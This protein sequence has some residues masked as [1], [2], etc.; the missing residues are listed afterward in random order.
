M[1]KFGGRNCLAER[2]GAEKDANRQWE[3]RGEGCISEPLHLWLTSFTR[4]GLQF[5][6]G[7]P[8][9]PA[10]A[11][12]AHASWAKIW[13][14][15]EITDCAGRQERRQA[16]FD[17]GLRKEETMGTSCFEI[18]IADCTFDS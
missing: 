11:T 7:G 14:T 1:N 10:A 15:L 13:L 8:A 17:C 4:S 3:G 2:A 9:G 12:M 6:H 5:S 18:P 16:F